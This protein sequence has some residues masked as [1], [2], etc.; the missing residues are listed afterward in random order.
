MPESPINPGPG[1]DPIRDLRGQI[2]NLHSDLEFRL[3]DLVRHVAK[4]ERRSRGRRPPGV[5][6]IAVGVFLGVFV[7]PVLLTI[8]F[9][10]A[11][12][13]SVSETANRLYP[14]GRDRSGTGS[15]QGSAI[16]P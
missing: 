8:L 7:V 6:S 1:G 4:I 13:A 15:Q 3:D 10:S 2:A 5:V 14:E 12:G 9:W 16:V 11:V